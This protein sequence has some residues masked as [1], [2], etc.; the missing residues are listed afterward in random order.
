MRL[1][2]LFSGTKRVGK[3]AEQLGYEIVSLDW[4]NADINTDI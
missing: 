4:K 1:L 3:I 2:D